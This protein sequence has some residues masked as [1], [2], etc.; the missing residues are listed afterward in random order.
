[1][2]IQLRHALAIVKNVSTPKPFPRRAVLTPGAYERLTRP[3]AVHP[4]AGRVS[5]ALFPLVH[6]GC[7][8]PAFRGSSLCSARPSRRLSPYVTRKSHI[9]PPIS[10]VM[11]GSHPATPLPPSAQRRQEFGWDWLPTAFIHRSVRALKRPIG[12]LVQERCLIGLPR[13]SPGRP[14]TAADFVRAFPGVSRGDWPRFLSGSASAPAK[15]SI[16]SATGSL[17][18]R[19]PL[20]RT[21]HMD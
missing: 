3:I 1:M 20:Y 6:G 11:S 17:R 21:A 2:G 10:P 18:L 4:P 8:P 9:P 13:A 19:S 15:A 12:L 14:S 5:T 16:A 7:P